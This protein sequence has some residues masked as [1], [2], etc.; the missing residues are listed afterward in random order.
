MSQ[1]RIGT[2]GGGCVMCELPPSGERSHGE[3]S[4]AAALAM[5]ETVKGDPNA[6]D[7]CMRHRLLLEE[8]RRM[9]RGMNPLPKGGDA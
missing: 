4:F 7:L 5:A 6:F 2:E 9:H 3:Q 1:V 8:H